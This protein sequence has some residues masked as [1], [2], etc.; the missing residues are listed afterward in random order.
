[1]N[2]AQ[3]ILRPN[4]FA[5]GEAEGVVEKEVAEPR[6]YPQAEQNRDPISLDFPH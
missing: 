6:E 4:D 1:M 5:E 3:P 2:T